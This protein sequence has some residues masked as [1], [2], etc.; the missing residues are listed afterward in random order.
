MKLS[1]HLLNHIYHTI[2]VKRFHIHTKQLLLRQIMW[3]II[4]YYNNTILENNNF[5]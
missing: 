1:Y 3:D 4:I 5:Y 2:I